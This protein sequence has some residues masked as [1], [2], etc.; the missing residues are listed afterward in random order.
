MYGSILA[1]KRDEPLRVLEIGLGT[2][3]LA[4][5]SNMGLGGRPGASLRA[6]RDWAPKAEIFGADIDTGVLFQ[7]K[8]ISTYFVNQTEG[9]SLHALAE[10]VGAN[11]DLIIDDGLHLPHSNLN[12]IEALLPLLKSNGTMVI[13][14][15]DPIHL[16]YWQVASAV[17]SRFDTQ[18]VERLG[19]YLF[20][21]RS[22][23]ARLTG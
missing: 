19:G 20:I 9:S 2:N 7:E 8:R 10:Q 4:F 6:F 11:F 18:L 13:E 22:K 21:I 14:D 5:Q 15:I 16:H 23:K 3:N 12:T 17:L 1:G